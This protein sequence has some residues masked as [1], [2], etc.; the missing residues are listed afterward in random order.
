MAESNNPI[1]LLKILAQNA[2]ERQREAIQSH[3]I[4]IAVHDDQEQIK[5]FQKIA[6]KDANSIRKMYVFDN[7]DACV[8]FVCER[9]S[10]N[11]DVKINVFVG[12]GLVTGIVS[13]IHHCEQIQ[14]ILITNKPPFNEEERESMKMYSKVNK[15]AIF[16]ITK[17]KNG[18]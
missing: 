10:L 16:C 5:A 3:I 13:S 2:I 1:N 11:P 4:L 12:G 6:A 18:N 17:S 15:Y 9:V 7:E 14:V 8:D